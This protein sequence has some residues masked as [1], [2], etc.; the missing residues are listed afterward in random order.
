MRSTRFAPI[1]VQLA[2]LFAAGLLLAGCPEWFREPTVTISPMSSTLQVNETLQM[3]ASSSIDEGIAWTSDDTDIVHVDQNG[4]VTAARPGQA[5]VIATGADSGVSAQAAL[6]V[7]GEPIDESNTPEVVRRTATDPNEGI[8]Q[9]EVELSDG[10]TFLLDDPGI[11]DMLGPDAFSGLPSK[12]D[13]GIYPVTGPEPDLSDT[14]LDPILLKRAATGMAGK[15]PSAARISLHADQTPIRNQNPRGLCV[16]HAVLAAVEARYARDGYGKLD[17]SEHFY[18]HLN[19][20]GFLYNFADNSPNHSRNVFENFLATGGGGN[21]YGALGRLMSYAT[22][23]ESNRPYVTAGG[24]GNSNQS[25]DD[26]RVQWNDR[27]GTETQTEVNSYNPIQ[28]QITIQIPNNFT[29]NPLPQRAVEN[30]V[31]SITGYQTVPGDRLHDVTWYEEQISMNREVIFACNFISNKQGD[32]LYPRD[33]NQNEGNAGHA[34]CIIGYD[35]TDPNDPYFIVKNS[36]GGS[37]YLKMSYEWASTNHDGRISQAAVITGVRDPNDTDFRPWLFYGRWKLMT[38]GAPST[39]DIHRDSG[40]FDKPRLGGQEDNRLGALFES[41]TGNVFRVN[42]DI[43]D[44]DENKD[45]EI[46][47][48]VDDTKPALNYEEQSGKNWIGYL[49]ND[50]WELTAGF[51]ITSVGNEVPFYAVKGNFFSGIA[52]NNSLNNNTFLG[53]WDIHHPEIGGTLEVR[54][55][56]AS[57]N[58]F[59]GRYVTPNGNFIVVNGTANPNTQEF[60]FTFPGTFTNGGEF[61]GYIHFSALATISGKHVRQGD[62]ESPYPMVLIR[63]GAADV[64]INITSPQGGDTFQRGDNIQLSATVEKD[65]QVVNN[66]SVIWTSNGPYDPGDPNSG[67]IIARGAQ[68]STKLPMGSQD[69]YATYTG[70][71]SNEE[72]VDIVTVIVNSGQGPT[73][74]ITNP[75]DGDYIR[76]QQNAPDVIV[77]A[78]GNAQTPGGT[79]ITGSDLQWSYRESGTGSSFINAGTGENTQLTLRDE[80]CGPTTYDVRLTATD[81]NTG[82]STTTLITVTIQ[83]F[84]C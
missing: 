9:V 48:W 16:V 38:N 47:F 46:S 57:N 69:I 49:D 52:A 66:P 13:Q 80:H 8:P 2:C 22:C 62:S 11:Y 60:A 39:L 59:N 58:T 73:V 72:V 81:P 70:G 77:N 7:Q 40:F 64:T 45:E 37:G 50:D 1:L 24:F 32:I 29:I 23:P 5:N 19:K 10:S 76:D 82:A 63:N 20:M 61:T 36:W 41:G 21:V 55:I 84:G 25:G 27:S 54:S 74:N 53:S 12:H 6:T 18:Q 17:L 14:A 28:N 30:A 4:L 15:R 51:A 26:P 83:A 44:E 43:R 71:T 78:S 79:A 34:M 42:G 65:G 68:G 3:S 35:R 33:K 67:T 31:Y 56:N 75:N